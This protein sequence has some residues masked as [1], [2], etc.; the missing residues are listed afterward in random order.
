M[1]YARKYFSKSSTLDPNFQASLLMYG[2]TFEE[3]TLHSQAIAV[4]LDL[5]QK[6]THSYLPLF[7]VGIEY[8]HLNN[9]IM[10]EEYLNQ[11]LEFS[12]NNLFVLHELGIVYY[13]KKK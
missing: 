11:A 8:S 1:D 12:P 13:Q 5:C 7:Y 4:Y 6:M 9:P 3:E 2:H 10:A